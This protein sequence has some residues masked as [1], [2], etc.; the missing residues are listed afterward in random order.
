MGNR[1]RIIMDRL[2]QTRWGADFLAHYDRHEQLDLLEPEACFLYNVKR[3]KMVRM[4]LFHSR[5]G[6]NF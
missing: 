2:Y 5:S 6:Y 1:E 4:I 3:L